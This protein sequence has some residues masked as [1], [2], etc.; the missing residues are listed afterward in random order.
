VGGLVSPITWTHHIYWFIPAVVIMLDAGLGPHRATSRTGSAVPGG[1][2]G[3]PGA[4]PA[5]AGG[6][7]AARRGRVRWLLVVA[8]ATY[9][10]IA[11]GVVSF[12]DWGAGPA[13]TDD[14]VDVLTRNTYVLLS[15]VLL[16]LLPVRPAAGDRTAGAGADRVRGE[17]PADPQVPHARPP[18]WIRWRPKAKLASNGQN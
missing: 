15:L 9:L 13:R 16:V 5:A 17:D 12:Q 8:T 14:P 18:R 4:D 6:D 11:Y 10:V 7:A 1:D 2:A 3:G